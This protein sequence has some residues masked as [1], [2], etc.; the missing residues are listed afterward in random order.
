MVA[1]EGVGD[2]PLAKEYW[3]LP[4]IRLPYFL[5]SRGRQ[6]PNCMAS[7]LVEVSVVSLTD[8]VVAYG[9]SEELQ[10]RHGL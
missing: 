5:R 6:E 10:M 8:L 7:G 9:D 1:V 2:V 4:W 3:V